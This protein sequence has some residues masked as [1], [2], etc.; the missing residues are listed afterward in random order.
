MWQHRSR[1]Y[2]SILIPIIV[3]G[4]GIVIG[5]S[6]YIFQS[7]YRS[8][9]I[10]LI[11]E[12]QNYLAQVK[13]NLE[14]KVKTVEYSFSSYS[15]TTAFSD[16]IA[17]P[18]DYTNFVDVKQ[19]SHELSYISSMS[20]ESTTYSLI[21]TQSNW[22]ISDGGGLHKLSK[23]RK[24]H[25]ERLTADSG[26]Q[27]FWHKQG[28]E[29]QML[30]SLP[31]FSAE[32][33]AIGVA[34]I[35]L[36]TIRNLLNDP[37]SNN[38]G[39]VD[40]DTQILFQNHKFIT[41]PLLQRL[42]AAKDTKDTIGTLTEA[43][44]DTLLYTQSSYNNWY[45]ITRLPAAQVHAQVQTLAVG[46][47]MICALLLVLLYFIAYIVAS[48]SA[49]S[50]AAIRDRL[51]PVIDGA[52]RPHDEIADI[53]GNIDTLKDEKESLSRT[54]DFQAPEVENLFVLN[55]FRDYVD[56]H[57]IQKRLTQ[58]G[59]P[60]MTEKCFATMLIQIDDYGTNTSADRDL[61]LTAIEN[62]VT[63]VIDAS[64]R[65]RPV[66]I[67]T[68]TQ[69]TLLYFDQTDGESIKTQL[70]T[71]ANQLQ[72]AAATYLKIK[73]SVGIS[74][75]YTDLSNTGAAAT[76][77]KQALH[78]RLSLGEESIISYDEIAPQLNQNAVVKIPRSKQDLLDAIRAG[79]KPVIRQLFTKVIDDIF[80]QNH[81]PMAIKTSV[82]KTVGD[83]IQLG[84]LLGI[85][86]ESSSDIRN[87]YYDVIDTDNQS[88]L[89]DLLY[90]HLVV[91]IVDET[92][93]R[94]N[95]D[96]QSLSEKIIHLIHTN[97]DKDISLDSIAD[98]L[99]YNPNYLSSVF[100]KE[101][102]TNFSDYLQAYRIETA[103]KWLIET[104]MTIK[105]IAARLQYNNP[106]NFIRFF[107]KHAGCTPV[108][109]RQRNR[110]L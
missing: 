103:K 2:Y 80:T 68:D 33:R 4:A 45:Y 39:I 47:V 19:V 43:N 37:I 38:I 1:F 56:K 49:N 28:H 102:G 46:M 26:K 44:G 83:L 23:A 85:D 34:N 64:H 108:A 69:A 58:F 12:R 88:Q 75:I 96:M 74:N 52:A 17:T 82:L 6:L 18:L 110:P 84:Q 24:A 94:T 21:S 70:L 16:L 79:N 41:K 27:L 61:V 104:D 66:L 31:F 35:R 22:E 57:D 55:L 54:L 8:I 59:Y 99:H 65:L 105:D 5:F 29:I 63:T 50:I 98:E 14:Q 90:S 77:A 60:D 81:N 107:K 7:T 109:Y 11:D 48:R 13:N 86:F 87:I 15:T 25:F 10:H 53:L 67:N 51:V 106:Q 32:R 101:F 42:A 76:N 9:K 93:N 40:G 72:K 89:I 100:K 92:V 36:D 3:L 73:I 91:P 95:N 97:V 78:F 62:I 20:M 71:Y 30:V